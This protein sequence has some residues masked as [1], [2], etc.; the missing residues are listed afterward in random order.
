MGDTA[1]MGLTL[2]SA[3]A[4]ALGKYRQA[5]AVTAQGDAAAA[6][7][8]QNAGLAAQQA[9]DATV[10]G[11][12]AEN[13][14][15]LGTRQ[16]IGAQRA[17][18]AAQGIDIASGTALDVQ[19]STAYVGEL[20]ALTVRNNAAREAWGYQVEAGNY[21]TQAAQAQAAARATAAGMRGEA[22]NTLLTG[23]IDSYRKYR[24]AHSD[25]AFTRK[26]GDLRG[27][28]RMSMDPRTDLG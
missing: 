19:A 6:V 28:T 23:A 13:L 9:Q 7:A 20:D 4:G 25:E 22:F 8:L 24:T 3:A 16:M 21:R 15:R 27:A 14:S 1:V 5:G 26:A 18:M 10:R 17:G 12:Q 11:A 2:G